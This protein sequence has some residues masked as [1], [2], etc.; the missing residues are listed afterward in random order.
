MALTAALTKIG[1][2]VTSFL[3]SYIVYY[4][5]NSLP[6][7][8]KKEQ[9]EELTSLL[10]NFVIYIW[11]GKIVANIQLFIQDPL[12][13]LAYPSSSAAFYV[14][15]LLIGIN[16]AFKIKRHSFNAKMLLYVFTPIFLLSSFMYELIQLLF[17]KNYVM[18]PY[19]S[20]MF[21]LVILV[22]MERF[23]KGK[24]LLVLIFIWNIA[25]L[26]LA[27]VMP[28]TRIFG[29]L[30]D[31]LFFVLMIISLIVLYR[32]TYKRKVSAWVE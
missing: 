25:Q 6:H 14:A 19:L 27:I 31:P 29:Y 24:Q 8:S 2:L 5:T 15:V 17:N 10:I 23:N 3:L 12:S 32:L 22:L 13:V 7:Q 28:Y 4:F 9:L 20:V 30:I 18:L 21:I 1:I 11:V 26:V 16:V